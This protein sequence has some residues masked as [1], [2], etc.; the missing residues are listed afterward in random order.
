MTPIPSL[1]IFGALLAGGEG[2]LPAGGQKERFLVESEFGKESAWTEPFLN[3]AWKVLVRLMDNGRIKPPRG[4]GVTLEKDPDFGGIGG[5]AS[6]VSIGFTSNAWP[7]D[8]D[9]IWILAHEL[10]NLFAAHYGGAGGFPADWWSNGRSPFPEYVSCLVMEELGYR[11]AAAYRREGAREKADHVLFWKL[12]ERYGFRLFSRFFKLVSADGL[13][14]GN[15]GRPWPFPDEARAAYTIAY[16][17]IAAG[18]NL[19]PLCR[20][21]LIGR[22]PSDWKR[23]HPEIVFLPYNVTT[24]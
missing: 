10:T 12:H 11:E 20:E 16:L 19:A 8:R 18:T 6:P 2:V 15:V 24:E 22:E 14:M 3:D 4:I 1:M 7:K 5:Y 17:S 9:R 21:H 23:I 13:D